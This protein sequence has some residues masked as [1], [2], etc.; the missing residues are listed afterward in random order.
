MIKKHALIV[1]GA[2]SLGREVVEAYL[3]K[4]WFTRWRVVSVD[5]SENKKAHKNIVLRTDI[6]AGE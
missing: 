4:T 2:G 5:Y 3:K 1:G 6:E